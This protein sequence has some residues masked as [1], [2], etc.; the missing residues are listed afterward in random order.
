MKFELDNNDGQ[1]HIND[2]QPNQH[3]RVNQQ[4][5]H[6]SLILSVDQLKDWQVTDFSALQPEHFEQLLSYQPDVV[7]FGSGETM[8]FPKPNLTAS[9]INQHIGVEVMNTAAACRTFTV[10]LAEQRRVVAVLL[11]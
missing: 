9:L 11:L 10:L 6:H 4:D 8:C 7:L 2:Y 3:I 1:Y 5:Y